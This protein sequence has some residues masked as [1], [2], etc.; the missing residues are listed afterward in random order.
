MSVRHLQRATDR[1]R[2]KTNQPCNR[3]NGF[4]F[5]RHDCQHK[6]FISFFESSALIGSNSNMAT[7]LP[8]LSSEEEDNNVNSDSEEE[9]ND[10][11]NQ[12]FSFG[13]ILVSADR[14]CVIS[15]TL[16]YSSN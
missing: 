5:S 3:E 8:S 15:V 7:L 2:A 4:F 11:V 14:P 16:G 12:D 1:R 10:E 13:G 9:E 6:L